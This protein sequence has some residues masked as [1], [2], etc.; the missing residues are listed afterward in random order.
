MRPS[1]IASGIEELQEIAFGNAPLAFDLIGAEL[2]GLD[3]PTD[4]F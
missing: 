1:V 2:P 4:G 3:Q